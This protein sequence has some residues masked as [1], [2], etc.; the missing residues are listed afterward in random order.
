MK[1][2]KSFCRGQGVQALGEGSHRRPFGPSKGKSNF[3]AGKKIACEPIKNSILCS[4]YPGLIITRD[5]FLPANKTI[6]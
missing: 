6:G 4:L 2:V 5:I 1:L 3:M